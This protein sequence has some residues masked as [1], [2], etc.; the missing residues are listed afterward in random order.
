MKLL[1]KQVGSEENWMFYCP[2]CKH[3]HII[4]CGGTHGPQWAYQI[5]DKKISFTP[6]LLGYYERTKKDTTSGE[7][8][9]VTTC[10]LYVTSSQIQ[11][12][13]DCPH[14]YAGKTVD[15]VDFP[16][17]YG[18]PLGFSEVTFS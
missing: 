5:K 10:H 4:P 6:S 16:E 3:G 18:I 15:F 11:F 14:E 1:K 12:L 9:R 13:A 7:R 17:N 8:E 2:G